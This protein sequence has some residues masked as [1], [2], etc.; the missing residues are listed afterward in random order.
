MTTPDYTKCDPEADECHDGMRRDTRPDAEPNTFHP[1]PIHNADMFLKW[2]DGDWPYP[3]H[4]RQKHPD[5]DRT[6]DPKSVLK[7]RPQLTLLDGGEF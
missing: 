2:R 3:R 5:V 7:P 6:F 4:S 1:C